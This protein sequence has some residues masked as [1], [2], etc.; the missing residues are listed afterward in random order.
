MYPHLSSMS[1][2]SGT[3]W[4]RGYLSRSL[5]TYSYVSH[6]R[7]TDAW[8]LTGSPLLVVQQPTPDASVRGGHGGEAFLCPGSRQQAAGSRQ[9]KQAQATTPNRDDGTQ[10]RLAVRSR[11][12]TVLQS[13][14]HR[15]TAQPYGTGGTIAS[16][17]TAL[18]LHSHCTRTAYLGCKCS[19]TDEVLQ[20]HL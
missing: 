10:N 14:H 16:L 12:V 2:H 3:P 18:A 4:M 7:D 6:S 5:Q 19:R 15:P 8:N 11:Y 17:R 20:G 1:A 13:K 9:A